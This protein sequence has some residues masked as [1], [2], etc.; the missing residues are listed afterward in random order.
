MSHFPLVVLCLLSASTGTIG[1]QM[2]SEFLH[3]TVVDQHS[4]DGGLYVAIDHPVD[5]AADRRLLI[6]CVRSSPDAAPLIVDTI[7]LKT[8]VYVHG[9]TLSLARAEAWRRELAHLARSSQSIAIF[10]ESVGPNP[11]SISLHKLGNH[12]RVELP[13]LL[14]DGTKFTDV[15]IVS[16]EAL[17]TLASD[18]RSAFKKGDSHIRASLAVAS[19][20]T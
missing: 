19:K 4:W 18:L 20:S 3:N 16:N 15:A 6:T 1:T 5:A 2:P 13:G 11:V 7:E 12:I 9:Y 8:Y 14:P 10:L 17:L